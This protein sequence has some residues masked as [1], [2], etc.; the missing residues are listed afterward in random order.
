[1]KNIN[2]KETKKKMHMQDKK[3]AKYISDEKLLHSGEKVISDNPV[4]IRRSKDNEKGTFKKIK[5]S[6]TKSGSHSL[7]ALQSFRAK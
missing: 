6:G 3:N 2:S 5:S 7:T 1:M 4:L